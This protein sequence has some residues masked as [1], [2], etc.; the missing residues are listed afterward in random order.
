MRTG[1]ISAIL[2]CCTLLACH[3]S[4]TDDSSGATIT[5]GG[6]NMRDVNANNMGQLGSPDVRTSLNGKSV[7]AYPNPCADV[8]LLGL[9][10]PDSVDVLIFI[11]AAKYAGASAEDVANSDLFGKPEVYSTEHMQPAGTS[12]LQL[13][14]AS[15]AK[16][17]Y[18]LYLVTGNDTLWDNIQVKH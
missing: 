4:N 6:I 2:L 15:Y 10:L 7:V 13:N 9:T 17:F 16:G 3:K 18:R 1:Y 12:S 11:K 5:I 14:T 8:L